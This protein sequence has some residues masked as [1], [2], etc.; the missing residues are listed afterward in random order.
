MEKWI[1]NNVMPFFSFVFRW[2]LRSARKN[3]FWRLVIAKQ[4]CMRSG[5]N[6][7]SYLSSEQWSIYLK[8]PKTR[9]TWIAWGPFL[10]V[11]IVNYGSWCSKPWRNAVDRSSYSFPYISAAERLHKRSLKFTPWILKG[12][13]ESLFSEYNPPSS[14]TLLRKST[15]P[16]VSNKGFRTP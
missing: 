6:A 8:Y 9:F 14:F 7:L 13:F 11:S 3:L 10:T 5:F 15:R 12:R 2:I 4:I 1:I 16:S